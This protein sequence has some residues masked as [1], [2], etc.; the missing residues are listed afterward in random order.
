MLC[1]EGGGGD[2]EHTDDPGL[3]ATGEHLLRG[4]TADTAGRLPRST[5]VEQLGRK[6]EGVNTN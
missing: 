3:E 6:G 1:E 4:V 2:V 5:E